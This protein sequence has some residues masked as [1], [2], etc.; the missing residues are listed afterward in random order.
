MVKIVG[1]FVSYFIYWILSCP[2]SQFT[3]FNLPSEDVAISL[4]LASRGIIIASWLAAVSRTELTRFK[5]FVLW[6]RFGMSV[7]CIAIGCGDELFTR[8]ECYQLP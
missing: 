6:L 8:G 1:P 2:R 7:L 5:E 3:S 4:E